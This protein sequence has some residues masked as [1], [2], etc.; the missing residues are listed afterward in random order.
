MSCERDL[1]RGTTSSHRQRPLPERVCVKVSEL[2]KRGVDN[3]EEWCRS[4]DNHLATRRGRVFIGSRK[5]SEDYHQFSYKASP[6]CNPYPVKECTSLD[7][8]LRKYKRY[9]RDNFAPEEIYSLRNMREIGCFCEPSSRC[10]V[11]VLIAY[12]KRIEKDNLVV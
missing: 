12:I 7:S 11:D 5:N 9:L 8:C 1:T 2:R 4:P 3:L 6:F 10:H